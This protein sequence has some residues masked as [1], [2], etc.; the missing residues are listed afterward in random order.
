MCQQQ[1]DDRAITA[2][3]DGHAPRSGHVGSAPRSISNCTIARCPNS[4]AAVKGRRPFPRSFRIAP[5]SSSRIV[6][7]RS[8]SPSAAAIVR[9]HTAPRGRDI[10]FRRRE[11]VPSPDGKIDRLHVG[12]PPPPATATA[13][14]VHGVC[15]FAPLSSSSSTTA[16]A[17]PVTAQCNG[18]PPLGS[19]RSRSNGSASSRR[20]TPATSFDCATRWM[21]CSSPRRYASPTLARVFQ[22]K[23]H[24]LVAALTRHLDQGAAVVRVVLRVGT[25]VEQ[26]RDRFQVPRADREM[27]LDRVPVRSSGDGSRS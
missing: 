23:R 7:T 6:V 12:G 25:G 27:Y 1:L 10:A 3:I 9:S 21:G 14:A 24:A 16:R 5:G 8:T 19:P 26:E 2:S 4:T 17:E 18:E 11:V 15:M 13:R 22:Q 20:R